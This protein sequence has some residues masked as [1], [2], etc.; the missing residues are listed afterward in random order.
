MWFNSKIHKKATK[1]SEFFNS[2]LKQQW[3]TIENKEINL[4][5]PNTSKNFINKTYPFTM[6]LGVLSYVPSR[7]DK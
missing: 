2:F 3:N 1:L 7:P 5:V 4:Q 6:V